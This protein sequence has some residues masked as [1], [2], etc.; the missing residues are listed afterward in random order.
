MLR[1]PDLLV[2][3][4]LL[5]PTLAS[6]WSVRSLADELGLPQAAVQRSLAR[7]GQTPVYD[8]ARKRVNRSAAEELLVHAVPFVA[9]T[10]LGAP[11]RGVP[12]AWATAPLVQQVDAG[13]ELP[14]VWPD[15]MGEIRGLAI[16]PLHEAAADAA[17]SDHWMHEMLALVDAMRIGDARTRGL[18]TELLRERIA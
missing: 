3:L 8:S 12:T 9:P 7:L 14:P 5:R 13:D 4:G 1:P 17:R 10:R 6:G 11:T 2:L 16:A 18:A 15:P